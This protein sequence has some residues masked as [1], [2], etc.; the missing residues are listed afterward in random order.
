[1]KLLLGALLVIIVVLISILRWLP[2]GSRYAPKE[3]PARFHFLLALAVVVLGIIFLW[4]WFVMRT[5]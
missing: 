4:F 5:T 2:W 3:E 1:M